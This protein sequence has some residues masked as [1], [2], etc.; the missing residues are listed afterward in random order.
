MPTLRW[1]VPDP[2][3]PDTQVYV[4]ASRFE[5]RSR[6]DT[7]RFFLRSLSA[8]RQ[9]RSAP[10]ALGASLIAHPSK[11]T[12]YTL[13]WWVH[14]DALYS[15]ARTEPHRGIMTALRSTMKTSAFTFWEAPA[16]RL[17]IPWEEAHRRLADQTRA[18][19]DRPMTAPA[20]PG[21]AQ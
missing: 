11:R 15:Y 6:R 18:D 12:F 17:P 20:E 7:L 4:M 5:V 3:S 2:P 9:V 10:G 1:A 8:W 21:S 16:D 14:R 13:S 19:V